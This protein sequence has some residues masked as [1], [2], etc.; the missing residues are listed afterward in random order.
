MKYLLKTTRFSVLLWVSLIIVQL[1]HANSSLP[2]LGELLKEAEAVTV[3]K[4]SLSQ[5]LV[6]WPSDDD[7]KLSER[8]L[9]ILKR[10]VGVAEKNKELNVYVS[11][12]AVA[13]ENTPGL[14][15]LNSEYKAAYIQKALVKQ[16][17]DNCQAFVAGVGSAMNTNK[18][19]VAI[20]QDGSK[21][22]NIVAFE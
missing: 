17:S 2:Q 14:S 19:F 18:V 10:V 5:L 4:Q 7:R 1:A 12:S 22:P 13:V 6:S 8:T 3:H 16:C 11:V 21:S 9:R 15:Q 20:L